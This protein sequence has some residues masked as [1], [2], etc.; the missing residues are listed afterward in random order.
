MI[1][2]DIVDLQLAKIQSNWKRCR[3]IQ[4]LFTAA[5]QTYIL[6]AEVPD[7]VV[8][9]LWSR[10]EAT[11]KAHQRRF[12]LAPK[13]NPKDFVC[14]SGGE[15]HIKNE[16]YFTTTTINEDYIYSTAT[17]DERDLNSTLFKESINLVDEL[18]KVYSHK[19]G[20]PSTLISVKKDDH[21]IPFLYVNHKKTSIITS[22]THHGRFSGIAY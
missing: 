7:I 6:D 10:K 15:V 13:F 20:V 21:N 11:Y 22:L 17:I 3:W 16:V 4:K 5:E 12:G 18:K 19:L 9:M 2:N 14:K 1:G 8:W